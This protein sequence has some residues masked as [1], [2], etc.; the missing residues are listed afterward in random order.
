MDRGMG[1]EI[2]VGVGWVGACR[3]LVR[4]KEMLD[5]RS[6]FREKIGLCP[7]ILRLPHLPSD[8]KAAAPIGSLLASH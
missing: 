4:W 2:V 3:V 8:G 1:K 6:H 5:A 7:Q